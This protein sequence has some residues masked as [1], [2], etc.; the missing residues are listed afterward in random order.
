MGVTTKKNINAIISGEIIFPKKRPNINQSL[1]N[2][3]KILEFRRPKI[4][5]IIDIIKGKNLIFPSLING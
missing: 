2:G 5:K 3:D 4:K 1:F